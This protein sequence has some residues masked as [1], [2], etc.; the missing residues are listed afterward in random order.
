MFLDRRRWTQKEVQR[1]REERRSPPPSRRSPPPSFKKPPPPLLLLLGGGCPALKTSLQRSSPLKKP[2][3]PWRRGGPLPYRGG[4]SFRWSLWEAPFHFFD[5]LAQGLQLNQASFMFDH[6]WKGHSTGEYW[7]GCSL[8]RI[9]PHKNR[10][11]S[12]HISALRVAKICL[13]HS[14]HFGPHSGILVGPAAAPRGICGLMWFGPEYLRIHVEWRTVSLAGP[15]SRN[16]V[17]MTWSE[18]GIIQ[19]NSCSTAIWLPLH[20]IS[21]PM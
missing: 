5:G 4:L 2:P 3:P 9:D 17:L 7:Y 15:A 8:K 18:H 6:V 16:H 14:C 19:Y 11:F 13:A 20:Y 10:C 1:E 21:K 12:E